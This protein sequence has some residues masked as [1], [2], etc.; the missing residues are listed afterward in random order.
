MESSSK[1]L[2][3]GFH[4]EHARDRTLEYSTA[5]PPP[6]LAKT[7]RNSFNRSTV[8]CWTLPR[9]DSLR[10]RRVLLLRQPALGLE[11]M[12]LL[13]VQPAEKTSHF[14]LPPLDNLVRLWWWL[15]RVRLSLPEL[16]G[17]AVPPQRL[18]PL[19]RRWRRVACEHYESRRASCL[20]LLRAKESVLIKKSAVRKVD[21]AFKCVLLMRRL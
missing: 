10:V 18:G 19:R 5:R 6:A 1:A 9:A 8:A 11:V 3:R 12:P 20:L 21:E 4:R 17:R 16:L 14:R 2:T 15:E 7:Q 13:D